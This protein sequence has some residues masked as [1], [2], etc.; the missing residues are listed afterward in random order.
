[1]QT[2]PSNWRNKTGPG[3]TSLP[4]ALARVTGVQL[5]CL[6]GLCE[7]KEELMRL[8]PAFLFQAIKPGRDCW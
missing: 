3:V 8:R 2:Q 6:H 7:N 4:L 5:A 1:M